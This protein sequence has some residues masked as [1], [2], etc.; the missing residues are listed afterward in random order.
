MKVN[1]TIALLLNLI[2]YTD[3]VKINQA[4]VI[5]LNQHQS[6]RWRKETKSII[7]PYYIR[8]HAWDWG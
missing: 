1:L 2:S 8:Y 6:E 4:P 7:E 5:A 3:A